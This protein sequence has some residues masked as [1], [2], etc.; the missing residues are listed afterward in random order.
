MKKTMSGTGTHNHRLVVVSNRLPFSISTENGVV[1]YQES[2]GG[3]VSGLS[4]YIDSIGQSAEES[5]D[6]IW[7]GW[8]GATVEESQRGGVMED[9]MRKFRSVPVF[10]AQDEMDSFYHGFCNKTIWPLFHYFP[11]LTAYQDEYW[12]VYQRVNNIFCDSL[13]DVLKPDDLVWIHDYHLMLLPRLLRKRIPDASIGFFLHIPFPAFEMFRLLPARWRS[14]LLNGMLGSDLIGFHTY[15]YTQHFLQSVLRILGHDHHMGRVTTPEHVVKVDTFPL[16]IDFEKF[17]NA[18]ADREVREEKSQLRGT[19]S[20]ARAILSVDRLDY[21]KGILNRL[22]GFE[23]LLEKY[24]QYREKVVF[25]MVVVPSRV[26]VDQYTTMR[27]QIDELVGKING[28]YGRVGWT[29]VVY[30]YRQIPFT[31]LAALYGFSDVCLVTPLRDGMNLVAKEYVASR[32]EG[33]GVL[34]LSEMAGAAKELP[35]AI[36]INPN[37]RNEI[38]EAMHEALEIPPAEQKQR[39]EVMQDRLRRYPAKRWAQDIVREIVEMRAVREK[40]CAKLLDRSTRGSIASRY[41][42]SARRL[43]LLDYDGTLVPI[44]RRPELAR[45][46][47]GVKGTLQNLAID[48]ANDVVIVSGRDRHTLGMWLGRLPVGFIAEHGVWLR[49]PGAEWRMLKQFK[50]DW[51]EGLK[52]MLQQYADRVPGA[53]VEEKEHSLVWHYRNA[54]PDQ[55]GQLASELMDNLVAFTANIDVHILH[56]KKVVEIRNAGVDKGTA[57]LEWIS[58]G[59]YDFIF[60]AGD[61]WTDEDLFKILPPD[62]VSIRVGVAHTHAAYNVRNP[63]EMVSFLEILTA[64]PRQA[65]SKPARH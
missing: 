51:K 49:D 54:D 39:L 17:W 58:R 45:P 38:A 32:T 35:E 62:A 16:G 14:E 18:H 33:T 11:T 21:T 4:A 41:R 30:Q 61:D 42:N 59:V 40:F 6:Y 26:A 56:G 7:V 50:S 60:A 34:I 12:D 28:Q 3:L 22:E 27:K 31:N 15:E 36:V 1:R 29:P 55:G 43:I 65:L 48:P 9:A 13:V 37:N 19:L 23:I 52:P 8:P 64:T 10:L 44:V 2:A 5:T 25:V 46:D 20:D 57:A 63:A 47:D 24:P 53:F